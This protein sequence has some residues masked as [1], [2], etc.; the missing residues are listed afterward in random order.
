MNQPR[1]SCIVPVYNGDRYLAEALDSVLGQTYAPYEVI[2]VDDGST[3]G[4]GRVLETYGDRVR[5][6]S[7]ANHGVAAARNRGLELARGELISFQDSDDVWHLEKLERQVARF[8][9][10]PELEM[11]TAFAQNFWAPEVADERER[12]Q[13]RHFVQAVPAYSCQVL[14]AKRSVFDVVGTFRTDLR[15]ASDVEWLLR[16]KDLGCVIEVLPDLLVF[17]RL[18]SSNLTRQRPEVLPDALLD[19]VK[20]TL[21]R[22]RASYGVEPPSKRA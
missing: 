12:Y 13:G 15:R 4:T 8:D 11:C 19:A 5:V 22:R 10:R 3:D 17:R 2:V 6:E 7:Q 21:D 9:A 16:A 20:H 1:V 14:L 18:H